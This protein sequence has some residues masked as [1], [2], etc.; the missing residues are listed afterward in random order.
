MFVL[1]ERSGVT[2][3]SWSM[4][5]L[6][7]GYNQGKDKTAQL[8]RV[9]SYYVLRRNKRIGHKRRYKGIHLERGKAR[10]VDHMWD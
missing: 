8:K 9:H 3:N 10:R 5:D 1:T 4:T 2:H 6:L 7:A